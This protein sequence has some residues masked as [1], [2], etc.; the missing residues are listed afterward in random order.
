M[1]T[2]KYVSKISLTS[3]NN[4]FY[5]NLKSI[6]PFGHK[7]LNPIFLINNIRIIKPRILKNNFLSFFVKGKSNRLISSVAFALSE[8]DLFK[9]LLFNKKE[10]S[11]IVQIKENIWNNKKKL[12]LVVLDAVTDLNKA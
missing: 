2:K 10:I 3:V 11:L 8:S 4:Q 6:G 9:T 1:I 7:N 5:N 12:Q